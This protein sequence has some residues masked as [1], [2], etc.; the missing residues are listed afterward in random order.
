MK[1]TKRKS[2]LI[3][4]VL[5][6]LA[7]G[8]GGCEDGGICTRGNGDKVTE[9]IAVPEFEGIDM[10]ISGEVFLTQGSPQRVEVY[11][12]SNLID[13]LDRDVRN[14]IWDIDF[15]GCA[16]RVGDFEV[17]ITV[18][19]LNYVKLSGSGNIQTENRFDIGDLD[20]RLSGSGKLIMEAD[21]AN[22]DMDLSGSGLV[23]LDMKAAD[24]KSTISGSGKLDIIGESPTHDLQISGSGQILGFDFLTLESIARISGSGKA[25]VAVADRLEVRI[26]GSGDVYYKGNPQLDVNISGSGRV[27]NAN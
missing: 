9:V 12:S 24:L 22:V 7:L 17:R 23:S 1:N 5:T 15:R 18:P 8:W 14:G 13:K 21:A 19:N 11:G 20:L 2:T 4:L 10:Q 26:S 16:S 3:L 25:E 6:A 27:I